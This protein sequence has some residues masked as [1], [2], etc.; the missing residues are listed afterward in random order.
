VGH[1]KLARFAAIKEFSNVF[2]LDTSMRGKWHEYFGNTHPIV[3]ELACG[4]G[5]YTQHRAAQE[6]DKNFIGIDIKGNR[7]FI[8]ARNCL[9]Q[10]I[11]NAAYLRIPIDQIT[12]YFAEAEIAEIWIIFPDPFL[13]DKKAKNRL[14]HQK[15]LRKYQQILQVGGTINLKTDSKPL[16]DF[17]LDVL[18]ES[19]CSID[20]CNH[21]IYKEGEAAY[22][23]NIKTY[24]EGMHLADNRTIQYVRFTLPGTEVV[25]PKKKTAVLDETKAE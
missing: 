22:P 12:D 11:R 4:K 14:T 7:M 8:G 10:G 9:E 25:V 1:K 19:G 21:N 16:F 20:I 18:Q 6:S 5:E 15:F 17:T 24:Y 2:E 3:L 13:R 23:L